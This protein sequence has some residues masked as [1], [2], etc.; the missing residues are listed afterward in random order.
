MHQKHIWDKLTSDIADTIAQPLIELTGNSRILIE[1]HQGIMRYEQDV[2][3]IKMRYG[4]V[5][6]DG[7]NLELVQI[8]RQQLVITGKIV[9]ISLLGG[10]D[11]AA[12]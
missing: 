4:T 6:V 8:S 1:H 11:D 10:P 2:I 7:I 3:E 9:A 12:I 5:R